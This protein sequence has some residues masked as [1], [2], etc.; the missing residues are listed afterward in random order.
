VSNRPFEPGSGEYRSLNE[1]LLA[2][3]DAP[4][5]EPLEV[6]ASFIYVLARDL[7]HREVR[8]GRE[9]IVRDF[10]DASR[11]LVR[12]AESGATVEEQAEIV[13][14]LRERLDLPEPDLRKRRPQRGPS[15]T[16][17]RREV[18]VLRKQLTPILRDRNKKP[19]KKLDRELGELAPWAT[20]K[21]R[22]DAASEPPKAAACILVGKRHHLAPNTV[23]NRISRASKRT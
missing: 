21:A 11:Q 4:P 20:P 12:A 8:G 5:K 1:I 2:R 9:Q 19:R 6:A 17:L 15:D 16:K 23:R 13:R 14:D 3:R 22:R 10:E 18:E 7:L